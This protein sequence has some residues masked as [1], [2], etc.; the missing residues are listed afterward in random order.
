VADKIIIKTRKASSPGLMI[1]IN[2]LRDYFDVKVLEED[3]PIGTEVTLH[4][5]KSQTQYCRSMEYTGYLKT[6]IRFLKI[7]VELTDGG[8]NTTTIGL[9]QL[10]YEADGYSE[11]WQQQVLENFAKK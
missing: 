2:G 5:R 7:P 4:L 1:T 3:C 6:N 11:V 8:G 10:V 9:E